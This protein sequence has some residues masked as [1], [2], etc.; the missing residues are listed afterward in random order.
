MRRVIVHIP[1]KMFLGR[2]NQGWFDCGDICM[3]G[4]DE[5]FIKI[6][7]G[8]SEGR[9]PLQICMRL[10][11]DNIKIYFKRKIGSEVVDC[12]H[13]A[14]D[15]IQWQAFVNT[16]IYHSVEYQAERFNYQLFKTFVPWRNSVFH[17]TLFLHFSS[18]YK[19]FLL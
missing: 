3:H 14:E 10:L 4:W 2:K 17:Q 12:I 19:L 6:L 16:L 5:K 1:Y 15:R 7:V 13:M 9:R 11:E 18:Q 8:K